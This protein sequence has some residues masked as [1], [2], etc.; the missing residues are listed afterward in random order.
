MM[1]RQADLI[2]IRHGKA[3]PTSLTGS[4]ADRPLTATGVEDV[5]RLAAA[6]TPIIVPDTVLISSPYRRTQ[7]TA[8]LLAAPCERPVLY[9]DRLGADH[10]FDAMIDVI[11]EV[12]AATT[13]IVGHLPTIA[14]VSA[15]LLQMPAVTLDVPPGTALGFR[16]I[17]R[18]R[19]L[20]DLRW[21]IPPYLVS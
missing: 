19:M 8:V 13:I 20:A 21:M 17:S 10:S 6:L 18:Q 7:Q 9:D 16:W 12:S 3:E 11:R 14:V 1:H 4:D 15:Q 5:R 2:L